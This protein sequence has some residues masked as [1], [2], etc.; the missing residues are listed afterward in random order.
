MTHK[1]PCSQ[2]VFLCCSVFLLLPIPPFLLSLITRPAVCSTSMQLQTISGYCEADIKFTS[3]D[4]SLTI[5][6]LKPILNHL[7]I[8]LK[9]YGTKA[10]YR[11]ICTCLREVE[12]IKES[13]VECENIT[14]FTSIIIDIISRCYH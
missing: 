12:K 7:S 8:P 2:L 4:L 9:M 14:C 11:V 13:G 3:L 6:G 10:L 5:L 1:S